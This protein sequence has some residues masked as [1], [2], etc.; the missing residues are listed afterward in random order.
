MA[1][2]LGFSIY[3][4]IP[5]VLSSAASDGSEDFNTG[6]NFE[7]AKKRLQDIRADASQGVHN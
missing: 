5:S 7:T 6:L 3:A 2:I 1:T 4:F